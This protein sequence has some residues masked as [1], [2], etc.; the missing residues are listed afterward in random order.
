MLALSGWSG[1]G[2][3]SANRLLCAPYLPVLEARQTRTPFHRGSS[4]PCLRNPDPWPMIPTLALP[5]TSR[6]LH[7]PRGRMAATRLATEPRAM[8]LRIRPIWD[9]RAH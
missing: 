4:A 3:V 6:T 9:A 1:S 2:T 7:L 5:M 8:C